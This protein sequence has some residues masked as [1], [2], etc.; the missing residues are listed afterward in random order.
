MANWTLHVLAP[1]NTAP[2][3][4]GT[5]MLAAGSVTP[6][7]GGFGLT[8]TASTDDGNPNPP[9]AVTYELQGK[10]FDDPASRPWLPV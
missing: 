9:G 3:T 1:P 8:W 10:D 6:N 2:N 7:Q 5:P 4:P